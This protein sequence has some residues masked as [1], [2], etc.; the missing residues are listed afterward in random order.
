MKQKIDW[1]IVCMGLICITV[2][3]IYAISKGIN[4]I[5][6]TGVIAI[7]AGVTGFTQP[8]LKLMKGGT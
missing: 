3:E 2:L 7:I 1:K 5:L 6:L 8:Q 4:G